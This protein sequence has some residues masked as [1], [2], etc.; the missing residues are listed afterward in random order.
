MATFGIL[1]GL[2]VIIPLGT[3]SLAGV[4]VSGMAMMLTKKY[5]KKLAKAMKLIDIITSALAMFEMSV[6]KALKDGKIDEREFK[7]LS[8]SLT[9]FKHYA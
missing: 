4:S 9:R 3:I 1:V 8:K 6:S 7:M 5:Q 2:P